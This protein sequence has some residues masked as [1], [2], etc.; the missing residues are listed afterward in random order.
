M[1]R[2]LCSLSLPLVVTIANRQR[3]TIRQTRALFA[4]LRF[5]NTLPADTLAF[6]RRLKTHDLYYPIRIT[7]PKSRTSKNP[8]ILLNYESMVS[9][10]ANT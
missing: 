2:T 8:S 6:D 7:A 3:P 9:I 1:C 10:Q 4:P 5:F